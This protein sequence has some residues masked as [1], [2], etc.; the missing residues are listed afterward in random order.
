MASRRL[1]WRS[2]IREAM[3]G[4]RPL[5][6]RSP[7]TTMPPPPSMAGCMPSGGR[8]R[9]RLHT[10]I[11]GKIYVAGGTGADMVGNEL[12]VYDPAA[13]KWQVLVA[14]GVPRNHTA[15]GSIGGRFYVVGGSGRPGAS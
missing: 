14:M 6:S 10:V 3:P 5:P 8:A 13:D 9:A 11:G 1:R 4:R 15:G 12:E 7:R 2:T